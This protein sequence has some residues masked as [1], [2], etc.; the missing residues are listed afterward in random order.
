M[1]GI[2]L[3]TSHIPLNAEPTT[4]EPSI[5]LQRCSEQKKFG[6]FVRVLL[7]FVGELSQEGFEIISD[8]PII[9]KQQAERIVCKEK[10]ITIKGD[11]CHLDLNE[12]RYLSDQI[13]LMPS[14]GHYL[15]YAG[16]PYPGIFVIRRHKHNLFLINLVDIEQ[17]T[18]SVLRTESWPGW[19]IEVNKVFAIASRSYALAMM[20]QA[21][22]SRM[23]YDVKNTNL[24]Q[25]YQGIFPPRYEIDKAVEQTK[26][27]F[28]AYKGK[29]I[30]AMF[31]CC[32]GGVIPTDIEG[33]NFHKTPYLARPYACQHCKKCK[34]Y[35]WR[36]EC[37]P[38]ELCSQLSLQGKK[39]HEVM[40]TRKDKA[41]IVQELMFKTGRGAAHPVTADVL[42]KIM[43]KARSRCF[44]VRHKGNVILF[45]GRGFGHHLGICQ[46]GAREMVR[47]DWDYRRILRFY[48]PDTQFVQLS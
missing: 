35:T 6:P 11:H 8:K 41:G 30:V 28:L 44:T 24:H 43:K 17:Y 27:I 16:R 48:Y 36:V 22:K 19:P 4:L 40:I 23:V 45:T 21:R 12:K 14:R 15:N 18:A 46:W 3:F 13:C 7:G 10:I 26:G 34:L 1:I 42:C 20:H 2:A 29:P 5:D 37:S 39:V 9:I 32:C 33:I 25:T 47:D 38:V 31:D